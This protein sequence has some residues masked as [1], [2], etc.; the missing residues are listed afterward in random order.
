MAINTLIRLI[1]EQKRG[2]WWLDL[3]KLKS[4]A[5]ILRCDKQQNK[6]K[7]KTSFWKLG[8]I[9]PRIDKPVSGPKHMS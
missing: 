4:S 5:K 8:A 3:T 1:L 2:A 7:L 9:D 6:Q